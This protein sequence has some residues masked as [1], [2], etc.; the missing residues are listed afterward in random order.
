MG[1]CSAQERHE[2]A[3]VRCGALGA[4]AAERGA[5]GR[6][7]R[8]K[9]VKKTFDVDNLHALSDKRDDAVKDPAQMTS[10]GRAP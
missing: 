5:M 7:A 6:V 1:R 2:F 9:K 3:A 4:A 8:Y 10:A